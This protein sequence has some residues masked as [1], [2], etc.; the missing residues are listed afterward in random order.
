MGSSR[1]SDSR[2]PVLAKESVMVN[3]VTPYQWVHFT[4]TQT[5]VRIEWPVSI[6]GAIPIRQTCL[7]VPLP[8]LHRF[9][10]THTLIPRR[11]VFLVVFT[12]LL[13]ILD[14]PRHLTG[15]AVMLVIWF[16]LLTVV[17]AVEV[18]HSDGRTT[19]PVCLL[20]RRTTEHFIEQVW[21]LQ[22]NHQP[23]NHS[24]C[25]KRCLLHLLRKIYIFP[26]L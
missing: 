14:L 13:V 4:L 15:I 26:S 6:L 9:R 23:A 19:I 12:S 1:P 17:G 2:A 11:L 18:H 21:A 5:V 16:M 22:R 25:R 20:Q 7:E 24:C 8:E 10:M 3:A